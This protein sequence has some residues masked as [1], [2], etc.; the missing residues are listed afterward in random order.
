[1]AANPGKKLEAEK[2]AKVLYKRLMA[3]PLN[4]PMSNN[5][6]TKK[7]GVSTSFF[8]NLQGNKKRASEPSI[9]NLR[10]VL[11]AAGTTVPE[12]FIHEAEGRLIQRPSKQALAQAIRDAMPGL[13]HSASKRPEYLAQAVLD[14]LALPAVLEPT[15]RASGGRAEPGPEAGSPPLAATN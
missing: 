4:P 12:F 8:T 10:L 2:R 15:V 14:V 11:E 9:G 6:W 1:M 7:A 13:P 5:D 3:L